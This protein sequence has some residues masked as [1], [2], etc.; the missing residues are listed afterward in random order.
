MFARD[1]GAWPT[2]ERKTVRTVFWWGILNEKDHLQDACI[3]WRMIL[4]WAVKKEDW[5]VGTGFI[6]LKV[7]RSA[8]TIM[9]LRV[10]KNTG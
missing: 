9:T 6:W 4:T 2:W 8:H 7:R 10:F 5:R 3:D 1:R